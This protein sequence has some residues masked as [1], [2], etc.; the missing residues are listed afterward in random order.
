MFVPDV[1]AYFQSNGI[2]ALIYD[3]RSTGL[4]DGA[5]PNDI[6]PVKQ[7]E[8]YS[9]ALT[10]LSGLSIVDPS[11]LAFWGMSFAGT[12]S[13]CA[14]SLDKRAKAVI[15]VCP[16]TKFE[17]TPE[18]LPRV[19]SKAMQDRASQIA[20]NAPLYLPM[21]TAAGENPAGFGIGTTIQTYYKMLMWQPFTLWRHLDP[22]P[23]MFVV[24]ELDRL[25]PPEVQLGLFQTLKG[26][27]RYHV[28]A[29]RG[30]MDILEGE[31]FQRLMQRQVEFLRDAL[32]GKVERGE[33][34]E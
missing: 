16:L 5:P 20:G 18:K 25:S 4:S 1:A 22:M 10:F 19:L 27:K 7:T 12:V 31:G 21:L 15:A 6:D 14:A 24:P 3:P 9:D 11:Q 30:H 32:D 17:Y 8:D 34:E 13:L 26:P 23:V 28:E 29:G 33:V 2:T